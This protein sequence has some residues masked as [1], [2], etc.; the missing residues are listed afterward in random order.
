MSRSTVPVVRCIIAN[1]IFYFYV[2]FSVVLVNAATV[3]HCSQVAALLIK[4]FIATS[5]ILLFYSIVVAKLIK[6]SRKKQRECVLLLLLNKK[7]DDT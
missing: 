5:C 7:K 4:L 3:N 6:I 1:G 2:V